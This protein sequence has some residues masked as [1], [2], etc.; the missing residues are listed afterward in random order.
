MILPDTCQQTSHQ[1]LSCVTPNDIAWQ[2]QS[3]A[4]LHPILP[5][6]QVGRTMLIGSD[7]PRLR[8]EVAFIQCNNAG[9][10]QYKPGCCNAHKPFQCLYK[11]AEARVCA[12]V[13]RRHDTRVRWATHL[14]LL[15]TNA[16]ASSHS[17]H[18]E[19]FS[20]CLWCYKNMCLDPA[21]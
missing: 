16:R 18:L 1:G 3:L 12:H 4:T 15:Q 2:D 21:S 17:Q 5:S 6:G 11:M 7:S 13:M 20:S 9:S 19:H 14:N 10:V 8:G